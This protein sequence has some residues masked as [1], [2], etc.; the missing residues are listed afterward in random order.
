MS[1]SNR[2]C[3]VSDSEKSRATTENSAMM[4]RPTAKRRLFAFRRTLAQ[5]QL[6]KVVEMSRQKYEQTTSRTG[7][8]LWPMMSSDF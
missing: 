7:H 2:K 3:P 1:G 6:P 8:D 4:T 5:L